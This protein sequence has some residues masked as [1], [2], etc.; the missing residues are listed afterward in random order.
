MNIC[1]HRRWSSPSINVTDV[2]FEENRTM[3]KSGLCYELDK[4]STSNWK[5]PLTN[6]VPQIKR[7][8][9]DES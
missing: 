7:L 2:M 6:V 9:V 5:L 8:M 1:N 3:P 4:D